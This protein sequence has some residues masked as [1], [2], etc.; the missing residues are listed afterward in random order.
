MAENVV[1]IQLTADKVYMSWSSQPPLQQPLTQTHPRT[2]FADYHALLHLM[3]PMY[4]Q[5]WRSL[6][7]TKRLHVQHVVWVVPPQLGGLHQL[8]LRVIRELSLEMAQG[9]VFVYVH[10]STTS[11]QAWQQAQALLPSLI[12][13]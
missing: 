8:E 7:F 4:Q 13:L 11:M 6:S 5:Y 12:R 10:E 2:L 9:R 3:K 1:L